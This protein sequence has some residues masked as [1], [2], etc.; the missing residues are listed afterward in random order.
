MRDLFVNENTNPITRI[1]LSTNGGSALIAAWKKW[2]KMWY[3]IKVG[4]E[5]NVLEIL[6]PRQFDEAIQNGK[7]SLK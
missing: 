1:L 4:S 2:R 6:T 7:Y 5:N 3:I